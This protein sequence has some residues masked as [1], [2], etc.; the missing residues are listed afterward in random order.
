MTEIT[1]FGGIPVRDWSGPLPGGGYSGS[2][3]DLDLLVARAA[4]LLADEY[5]ADVQIRFNSDRRSGGAWLKDGAQDTTIGL[6]AGYRKDRG[7]L[8]MEQMLDLSRAEYNALPDRLVI[9]TYVSA[10]ALRDVTLAEQGFEGSRYSYLD[11]LTLEAGMD[12]LRANARW[13]VAA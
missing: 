1:R 3:D 9:D 6:C 13:P 4:V 7:G 8:T 12:W 10:R 11:H 5:G 2:T